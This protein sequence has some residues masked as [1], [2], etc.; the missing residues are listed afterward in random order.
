MW[1]L[2]TGIWPKV[3]AGGAAFAAAIGALAMVRKSGVDAQQNTD[4]KKQEKDREK[5][6]QATASVAGLDD[7][8]VLTELHQQYDRK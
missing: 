7:P 8:A 2:L 5:A 6:D 4:L 3:L 1:A